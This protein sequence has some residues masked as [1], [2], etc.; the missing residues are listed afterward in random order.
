[1]RA[2]ATR[3]YSERASTTL[4]GAFELG[5]SE[6]RLAFALSI[7]QLPMGAGGVMPARGS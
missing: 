2:A 7:D 4:Y 6:W 1:M 5:N 3:H